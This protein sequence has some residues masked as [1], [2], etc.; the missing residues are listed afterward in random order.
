MGESARP[1]RG[2]KNTRRKSSIKPLQVGK[3]RMLVNQ[4]TFHLVKHGGNGSGPSRSDTRDPG[5]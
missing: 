5:R 4:Q 3:A 2:S 1:A